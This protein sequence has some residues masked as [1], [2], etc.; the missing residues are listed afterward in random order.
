M[1]L[2]EEVRSETLIS[3]SRFIVCAAPV[4]T[5]DAARSYIAQIRREFP[6]ATHVCT[7]YL[8]REKDTAR[9]SDNGEPS[10]TA[11]IP[12]LEAIRH[13]GLTDTC[14]CVVRY[15]GGVK[16][17]TGGLSRAYGGCTLDTL[18]AAKKAE[19]IPVKVYSIT[20]PYDLSG[21]LEGWVRRTYEV[22]NLEY[23]EQVTCIFAGD[24]DS[25]PEQVRNLSK[26]KTEA[27]FLREE[28][29]EWEV[30]S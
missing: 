24:D 15:F 18:Q 6:E 7:A 9:S 2:K 3:K 23:G 16:L 5:E 26:G 4:K 14:V 1:R 11:G 21:V 12:I 30:T 25:I 8:L 19:D 10:G 29:R 13:S 27:T 20:Y 28:F 22:I 17:G